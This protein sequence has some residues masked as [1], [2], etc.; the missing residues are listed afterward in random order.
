VEDTT[1]KH[2]A[3]SSGFPEGDYFAR[4]GEYMDN[5]NYELFITRRVNLKQLKNAFLKRYALTPVR[6]MPT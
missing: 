3:N 4:A 1:V 2:S 6:Q 5:G